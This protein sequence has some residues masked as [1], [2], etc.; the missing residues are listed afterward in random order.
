MLVPLCL[1]S[2]L[3]CSVTTETDLTKEPGHLKKFGSGRP[4]YPIDEIEGFP[5]V[6]TFFSD[7]VFG[8]RPLKMKNAARLSPAFSLWTDEYFLSL[9]IDENSTILVETNKKENRSLPVKW[10]HFQE[11]VKIYNHSDKYM[12]QD[13]PPYLKKDVMIPCCIQCPDLFEDGFTTTVMWFSSGGTKSVIHT[14]SL[15]NINCLF[16]G[17]KDIVFVDP[18]YKDKIKLSTHGSYSDIDVD[19]MNYTQNPELAE[20]EYHHGNMTAGD[21]LYIPYMWIHQVRSYGSNLAV[22]VWWDH[23]KNNA[24]N[25]DQCLKQ[26]RSNLVLDDINFSFNAEDDE[27]LEL[28]DRLFD[29]AEEKDFDMEDLKLAILG[30]AMNKNLEEI[31]A[32]YGY[33]AHI[34]KIFQKL[35]IDQDGKVNFEELKSLPDLIWEECLDH[36]VE[37][38]LLVNEIQKLSKKLHLEL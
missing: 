4:S 32:G 26:C 9:D 15:D 22:N 20:I 35:D 28:Q 17:D 18:K 29:M 38:N 37:L 8:S 14:D 5:D 34:K 12:V 19:R 30:E 6:K 25:I 31:D 27:L 2:L 33:I 24:I 23:S 3:L 11:F 21:C 7:Y 1:L 10:M 36:M 16:R 13:V